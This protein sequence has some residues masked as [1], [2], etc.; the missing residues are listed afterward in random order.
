VYLSFLIWK[1]GPLEAEVRKRGVRASGRGARVGGVAQV[2]ELLPSKCKALSPK[3]KH[4]YH[5]KGAEG[6]RVAVV[7]RV[8]Q[9]SYP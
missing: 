3:F 5:K 7:T 2:V 9:F 1:L 4:Q 6:L 8:N